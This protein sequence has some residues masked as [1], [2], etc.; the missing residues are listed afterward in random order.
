MCVLG[1]GC[2]GFMDFHIKLTGMLVG[3]FQKNP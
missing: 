3:N 1:Q 2:G